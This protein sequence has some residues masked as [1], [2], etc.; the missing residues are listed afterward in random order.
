MEK[1]SVYFQ[2]FGNIAEGQKNVLT[3]ELRLEHL[4]ESSDAS[5]YLQSNSW[6]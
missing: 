4:P 5:K 1:L 2:K 6:E 3:L